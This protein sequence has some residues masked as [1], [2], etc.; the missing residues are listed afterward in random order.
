MSDR[1]VQKAEDAMGAIET[2]IKGLPGVRGYVK[3]ELRRDADWGVRQMLA[4]RLMEQKEKLLNIQK[5]MLKAGGLEGLDEIDGVVR[6]LQTLIDRIKTASQGY[7]GLFDAERI[8]E[9][10]L[11]ALH[12]FDVALTEEIAKITDTIATL[13]DAEE[14]SNPLAAVATAV[15]EM[16]SL[17]LRRSEAVT[18]P[19][20]LLDSSYA[21]AVDE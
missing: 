2:V 13:A 10:Q 9:G 7:A 12:R 6:N 20:L 3:K 14:K 5:G 19:D 11:A 17:V 8:G 21:P 18:D 15:A 16:N 1:F 4:T